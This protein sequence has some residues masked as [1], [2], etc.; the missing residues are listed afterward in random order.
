MK[1]RGRIGKRYREIDLSV[2]RII[3]EQRRLQTTPSQEIIE[4]AK[5]FPAND[6]SSV[7]QIANHVFK[8][9]PVKDNI[10]LSKER[11]ESHASETLRRGYVDLL[12]CYE[13]GHIL[14]AILSAKRM[15]AWIVLECDSQSF[16]HSYVE[17]I[18]G[19]SLCTIA[20]KANGPPILAKG[21]AEDAIEH[22]PASSFLRGLDMGNLG[23]KNATDFKRLVEQMSTGKAKG[24]ISID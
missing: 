5:R 9:T 17:T 20:F 6:V 19:K 2:A 11:F 8:V 16:V 21:R 24:T 13:R 23:V 4:I 10:F 14:A 7:R 12:H 22:D 18:V 3:G 1:P 15:Q